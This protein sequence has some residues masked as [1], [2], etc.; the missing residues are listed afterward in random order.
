MQL[1]VSCRGESGDNTSR[2]FWRNY[3]NSMF[4]ERCWFQC[5]LLKYL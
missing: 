5:W 1:P 2:L 3:T 4:G